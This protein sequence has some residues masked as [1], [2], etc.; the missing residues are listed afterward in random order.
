M[1]PQKAL[2]QDSLS[3]QEIPSSC[4]GVLLPLPLGEVYDYLIP[5]SLP[6]SVG[7]MVEVEFGRQR[8]KGLV[9]EVDKL[10]ALPFSKLKIISGKME[11]F[12]FTKENLDFLKWA[13]TYTTFPRGA[14]LKMMMS[15]PQVFTPLKRPRPQEP[16]AEPDPFFK[17]P[18]FE[19]QQEEGLA[20]IQK[21]VTKGRYSVTLLDGVT[22]SG[23]T[24]LYLEALTSCF[25]Q[26]KQAL[27]LVPQISLAPQ[28]A[29]RF[30]RRFGVAPAVWHSSL[31]PA[32]RRETWKQIHSGHAK[33]VIGARSSLFLPY[34]NLGMIVVDEEHDT[35]YKQEEGVIYHARDLAVARAYLGKFPCLLTS[36]T[37]SLET[38]YNCGLGKYHHIRLRSRYKGAQFPAVHLIDLRKAFAQ[39]E[40]K[41][42]IA[43]LLAARLK[44]TVRAGEQA[45]IYLNRRGY[46]PLTLCG[47]CGAKAQCP[48]CSTWLVHH[49]TKE[50]LL[51][52]HCGHKIHFSKN[53]LQ[54]G[55]EESWV[56]CGPGVER[57]AEEIALRFPSF[58]TA[59]ISSDSVDDEKTMG[60]L[61]SKIHKHDL[62]VL[63][64]TQMIAKGHH[65]PNLTLVGI[66]DGDLGLSGGDL[67]SSEK[68]YHALHQVAGRAGRE[69]KPGHV[70][71][72]TYAPEHPVLASLLSGEREA[73]I[74][75]E[76]AY[77][78]KGNMPPFSRLASLIFSSPHEKAVEEV[79]RAF[80]RHAPQGPNIGVFG[81]GPAPLALLRGNYR[82]R[83]LLQ[84]PRS[85]LSIQTLLLE[86]KN[87]VKVPLS[88]KVKVDIDPY[89]FL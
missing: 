37:P 51:C 23:K 73:F 38:L 56:F 79:A 24:E 44:E 39:K 55:A 25:L 84:T 4:A 31:T 49:R 71:L 57:I 65:F 67:R 75:Q 88:V 34:G 54:C 27:I 72:Q 22:G 29:H 5:S 14:L 74:A 21:E 58:R 8:L 80:A 35:A 76:M 82:W 87:R 12:S 45:L 43:P 13:S 66:I 19:A 6:V 68:T 86:W 33:A 32:Q 53:C 42:W 81:P 2:S 10:T 47:Q 26:G 83:M 63:I 9:W 50:A 85:S 15:V 60:E 30:E 28:I 62:D 36:A 89:S 52:H 64:G 16:F 78:Q 41:F 7:D 48:H 11:E 46:A 59:V 61:A 17:K 77:R 18:H 1:T 70:Y 40:E 3:P 69:E 20:L